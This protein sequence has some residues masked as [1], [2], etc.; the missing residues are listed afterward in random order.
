MKLLVIEDEP[1]ILEFLRL[2]LEAEGFVVDGAED[3]AVGL[4]SRSTSSYELVV[5]DLLLPRSTA[6]ACSR[7]LRRA[8]PDLP[9]LILSARSD[10]PTKLRSFDLGANDYLS[11]PF[12]FDELVARVRVHLRRSGDATTARRL[13]VGALELDLARR[14]AQRRGPRRSTSRI[15]SSGCST[16]SS[17]TPGEVV[18]R[19]RLLSEVW[20]YSFD[21][22]SNVVDVC[23]R[24][25]RKKLGPA[26]P[27]ETV[28]HAGY[29]L[30]VGLASRRRARLGRR[31]RW[32]ASRLMIASPSWETIPFHV[33]WISLTLLYGFRVW[34]PATTGARARASSRSAPA[35]RSSTDAFDGLQLW[36]EL[37]EVPLMSAM[38][39]AM[40]W[41]ARRRARGARDRR[42]ARRRAGRA[43]RA[44]GA[45]APQRLARAPHAGDDRARASRAAR[46]APRRRTSPSSTSRSTSSTR[47]ERI[48]D[49]ILLLARAEQPRLVVRA[50]GPARPV[51]RGRA[52]CA[53]RT[54]RRARGGSA[55]S[56]T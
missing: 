22:G 10:L 46:A 18:S 27:I 11:K 53:G 14:R 16:T 45:A 54:S 19:E 4:R 23:V 42:G 21:P 56:S 44:G 37:F 38:F 5:L 2:G 49:R 15:A 47:M 25:L 33:I 34:S 17:R 12:S 35:P 28:R 43:A 48:V 13:R 3:G 55:R 26:S 52:S 8:R 9:V 29:R 39:L 40:V 30:A 31:S 41:H 50:P 20:G 1:R 6:C 24:R 32:A 7:E 51:P 36:G